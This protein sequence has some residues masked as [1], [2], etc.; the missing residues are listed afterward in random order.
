LGQA[1]HFSAVVDQTKTG[2]CSAK[3]LIS[4][5]RGRPLPLPQVAGAQQSDKLPLIAVLMLLARADEVIE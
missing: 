4:H 3:R 5:R 1:E 2:F